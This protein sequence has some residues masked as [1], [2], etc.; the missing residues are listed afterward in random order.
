MPQAFHASV[1][2][3]RGFTLRSCACVRVC[4]CVCVCAL[5]ANASIFDGIL[6]DLIQ[7]ASDKAVP[8]LLPVVETLFT[9]YPQQ[10]AQAFPHTLQACAVL[11]NALRAQRL[12]VAHALVVCFELVMIQPNF[13]YVCVHMSAVG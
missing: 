8:L 4:V 7:D 3:G 2:V 12:C 13:L 1:R 5:Q 9:L 10:A 6:G 11:S